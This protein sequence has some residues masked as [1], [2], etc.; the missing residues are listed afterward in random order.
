MEQMWLL[1]KTNFFLRWDEEFPDS[2]GHVLVISSLPFEAARKHLGALG[3]LAGKCNL[4]QNEEIYHLPESY[5]KLQAVKGL[6]GFCKYL[7]HVNY[8]FL[9]GFIF[10]LVMNGS[11]G[12][13]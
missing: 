1:S 10:I 11:L 3:L 9:H 7:P 4:S 12:T 5:H 13:S 2:G 8:L 6:T